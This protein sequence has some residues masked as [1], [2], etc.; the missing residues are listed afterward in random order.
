ML[1]A[2]V[3]RP[4]QREDGQLEVVGV[5]REERADS[6]VLPVREAECAMERRFRHAAQNRSVSARPDRS[7]WIASARA[8]VLA[9]AAPPRGHV[10]RVVPLHQ[11]RGR[12]HPTG[13]DDRSQAR[14]RR[15]SAHR[16][17]HFDNGKSGAHG[18]SACL[19][20]VPRARHHQRS[21]P[22]DARGLGRDAHRL[23]HRR[24]R[25]GLRADLRRHPRAAVPPARSP[26]RRPDDRARDRALGS[27][28]DHRRPSGWRLVGG[29]GNVRSRPVLPVL[30]EW[31]HLRPAPGARHAGART[32]SGIDDRGRDRAPALRH[33]RSADTVAWHDGS[34][35]TSGAR[36]DSDLP[37]TAAPLSDAST[38]RQPQA[39]ARDVPDARVRCRLRRDSAR[40]AASAQPR[41][42]VSG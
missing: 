10:G 38:V 5:A 33:C 3:L 32:R 37:R 17:S 21:P 20:S 2:A 40:R 35:W 11:G 15:G 30:R 13:G 16:V 8:L 34:R 36:A 9:D 28:A 7:A 14:D 19:G 27:R 6:L 29:C 31:R 23:E 4:E 41:S 26:P 1:V 25:P 18:A 22:D 42:P 39:L 24:D 12:G